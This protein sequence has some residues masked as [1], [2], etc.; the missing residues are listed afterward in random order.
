MLLRLVY[1]RGAAG[2]RDTGKGLP[3]VVLFAQM[4]QLPLRQGWGRSG[5]VPKCLPYLP[6]QVLIV[7]DLAACFRAP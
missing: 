2:E 3:V 6:F 4:D 5:D 1:F 7:W